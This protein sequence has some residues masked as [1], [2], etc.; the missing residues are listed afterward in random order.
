MDEAVETLRKRLASGELSIAEYEKLL[1]ALA[2]TS[3]ESL[4]SPKKENIE[5]MVASFENFL[6]YESYILI[7]NKRYPLA[8]LT[9]V[10]SYAREV[11][12]NFVKGL[13]SGF[14]VT[15]KDG[16][17][18]SASNDSTWPFKR[19]RYNQIRQFGAK[20]KAVTA[21]ARMNNTVRELKDHGKILVGR[22]NRK[23]PEV[24][25]TIEGKIT[26]AI[27][28]FD[29]KSCAAKGTFGVGVVSIN[30]YRAPDTVLISNGKKPLLGYGKESLSFDLAAN[31]DV[32]RGLLLWF[33]RP[34]NSMV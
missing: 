17:C 27:R 2:K 21:E 22:G 13:E 18:H 6:L 5:R 26:T 8:D 25:L 19:E 23:E 31:E 28:E 24:Y 1:K 7:D 33:A 10:T 14:T 12:F 9:M 15:L 32:L 29:I 3:I 4:G 34:N 20:L 11:S 30:N 16:A